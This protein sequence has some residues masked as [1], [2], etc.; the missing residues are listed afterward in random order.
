MSMS[1]SVLRLVDDHLADGR[2]VGVFVP[3]EV[4]TRFPQS[5]GVLERVHCLHVVIR[6]RANGGQHSRV[7]A[8]RQGFLQCRSNDRKRI[9]ITMRDIKLT[10]GTG[11][12]KKRRL[13]TS[14]NSCSMVEVDLVVG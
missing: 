11:Q 3:V 4:D 14:L 5:L 12:K 7:R 6:R 9:K 13:Y 2:A 10:G 1:K 8:T